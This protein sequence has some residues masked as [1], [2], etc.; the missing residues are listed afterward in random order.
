MAN[1][2]L[3]QFMEDE[4]FLP[5][6]LSRNLALMAELDMQAACLER[7]VESR[8]HKYIMSLQRDRDK[9]MKEEVEHAQLSLELDEPIKRSLEPAELSEK[10]LKFELDEILAMQREVKQLLKE[11]ICIGDQ[12]QSFL[13]RIQGDLQGICAQP[14]N[15]NAVASAY[16]F[17]TASS[18]SGSTVSTRRSATSNSTEAFAPSDEVLPPPVPKERNGPQRRGSASSS[19]SKESQDGSSTVGARGGDSGAAQL[20]LTAGRA[21]SALKSSG[22]GLTSK[23]DGFSSPRRGISSPRRNHGK[24]EGSRGKGSSSTAIEAQAAP[25]LSVATRSGSRGRGSSQSAETQPPPNLSAA[26]RSFRGG[27]DSGAL[28]SE[29]TTELCPQ[30]C[31]GE[32]EDDMMVACDR[33]ERWFHFNCVQDLVAEFNKSLEAEKWYCPGCSGTKSSK[34]ANQQGSTARSSVKKKY[35]CA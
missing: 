22:S 30:C 25:I 23:A 11:K 1:D 20:S 9:G 26:T 10:E 19:V 33:C 27:E 13:R 12:C 2:P 14:N 21:T 32:R 17:Q 31:L 7:D 35:G 16:G 18:G 6:W 5:G 28:E 15:S 34:Q 4:K 29:G 8:K 24:G 3:E